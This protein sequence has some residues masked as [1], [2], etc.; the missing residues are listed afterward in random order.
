MLRRDYGVHVIDSP[1]IDALLVKL[2]ALSNRRIFFPRSRFSLQYFSWLLKR[3]LEQIDPD[4]VISV[5]APHKIFDIARRWPSVYITDATFGSI[6]ETYPRY[7]RLTTSSQAWSN[8][9]EALTLSRCRATMV[10]SEWA[11]QDALRL[12]GENA[13][14]V[15]AVPFGANLEPENAMLSCRDRLTRPLNLLFVGTDWTRKGGE[16]ALQTFKLLRRAYPDSLLH[17]V[18]D[19]PKECTGTEGVIHH[20]RLNRCCPEDEHRL[21]NLFLSSTFFLMPSRQEAYGVVYCEACA[22]GLP[23]VAANVGGVSAIVRHNENG[24]LPEPSA[25]A[26]DYAQSIETVWRNREQYT[27]M[28]QSARRSFENHLSWKC[29]GDGLASILSR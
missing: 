23:P 4:W 5:N 14:R 29:W 11:L 25:S 8:R 2:V 17:I 27:R 13:A 1:W 9:V 10:P 19:A 21:A 26:D 20:R 16:L 15:I 7:T 28:S 3:R 6:A 24:I 12:Y 22:F 18:G